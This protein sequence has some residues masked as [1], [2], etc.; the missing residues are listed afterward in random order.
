MEKVEQL[1]DTKLDKKLNAVR[2][3]NCPRSVEMSI[4]T[5]IRNIR[6]L[7]KAARI[8]K[9]LWLGILIISIG[10]L[11]WEVVDGLGSEFLQVFWLNKEVFL[12]NLGEFVSTVFDAVPVYAVITVVLSISF[13]LISSFISNLNFYKFNYE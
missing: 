2:K 5:E 11:V 4:R 9:F 13:F 1:L 12:S 10:Y 3:F 8:V 7:Q 6:Y